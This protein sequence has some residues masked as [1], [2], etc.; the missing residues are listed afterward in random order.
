MQK[1]FWKKQLYIKELSLIEHIIL[2]SNVI[3]SV[4]LF[5]AQI[6]VEKSYGQ[7]VV[8]LT[9]IASI[10]SI[11]SVMA[12]VKK[13]PLCPL[14]GIVA[15]MILLPIAWYKQIYGTMIMFG[16]NIIIQTVSFITWMKNANNKTATITPKE[17]QWWQAVIYLVIIVGLIAVFAWM[18]HFQWFQDFMSGQKGIDI[19]PIQNRIFDAAVLMLTLGC[20]LP[21]IL[22]LKGVWIMY[23]LNDAAQVC[24]W[25]CKICQQPS[26]FSSW[27]MLVSVSGLLATSI[28]GLVRWYL[29]D[30]NNKK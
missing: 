8:W 24:L 21:M 7:W 3:L 25:I 23:I 27:I 29:L 17:V 28:L 18:E 2:W 4:A 13:R 16:L 12:G 15:S 30:K 5:I 6:I 20:C 22:R 11:F 26:D 14:I 19:P 10:M 1:G 9:L